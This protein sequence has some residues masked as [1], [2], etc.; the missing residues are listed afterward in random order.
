MA[1]S[2]KSIRK[3]RNYA[4]GMQFCN[5]TNE[6]LSINSWCSLLSVSFA[7]ITSLNAQLIWR[8]YL[9]FLIYWLLFQCAVAALKSV[10]GGLDHTY[11]VGNAPMAHMAVKQTDSSVSSFKVLILFHKKI[12]LCS[13]RKLMFQRD[14]ISESLLGFAHCS[15]AFVFWIVVF[16]FHL[17]RRYVSWMYCHVV[18]S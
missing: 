5:F 10:L 18:V 7:Y 2:G 9:W 8:S 1:F 13:V 4:T 14:T 3:W 6:K 16:R 15:S 17:P 11:F 12:S